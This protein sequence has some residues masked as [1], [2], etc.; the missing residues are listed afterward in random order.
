MVPIFIRCINFYAFEHSSTIPHK[1]GLCNFLLQRM[2]VWRDKFGKIFQWCAGWSQNLR[3][4]VGWRPS[5]L[6]FFGPAFTAIKSR[7]IQPAAFCQSRTGHMM[8]RCKFFYCTPYIFVRHGIFSYF[9]QAFQFNILIIFDYL[10]KFNL[11]LV[12]YIPI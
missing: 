8:F 7:W 6:T 2:V 11:Y 10:N 3:N 1:C 5:W 12:V 4:T 9:F